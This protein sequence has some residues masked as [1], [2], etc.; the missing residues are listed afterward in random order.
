[1][2]IILIIFLLIPTYLFAASDSEIVD[3][4]LEPYNLE[5]SAETG[6]VKLGEVISEIVPVTVDSGSVYEIKITASGKKA[7]V[8]FSDFTCPGHGNYWCGSSGCDVYII[9]DGISYQT[10]GWKP[11]VVKEGEEVFVMLPKSGGACGLHNGGPCYSV[12]VW[13]ESENTFN[14]ISDLLR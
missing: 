4:L 1:V 8:L 6:D 9:I 7:T 11:F 10:R 5:C 12:A 2:R 3:Q 14:T 13:D